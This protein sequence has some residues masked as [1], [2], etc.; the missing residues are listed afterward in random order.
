MK[1][2]D[3][4]QQ[5]SPKTKIE[6]LQSD[7]EIIRRG[8]EKRHLELKKK[9]PFSARPYQYRFYVLDS[10][11]GVGRQLRMLGCD[12]VYAPVGGSIL[13]K[14]SE[15]VKER[16]ILI[17]QGNGFNSIRKA[18]AQILPHGHQVDEFCYDLSIGKRKETGQYGLVL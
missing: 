12:T 8:Q 9:D 5:R 2:K 11:A 6:T 17:S 3:K 13:S 15:A 4:T 18:I 10:L 14:C 16:R 7:P 1:I